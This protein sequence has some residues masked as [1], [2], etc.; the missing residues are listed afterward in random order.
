M[1]LL[2]AAVALAVAATGAWADVYVQTCVR[3]CVG[4]GRGAPC[5]AEATAAARGWGGVGVGALQ[6]NHAERPSPLHTHAC[7]R[8]YNLEPVPSLPADFGPDIDV[9]GVQGIL[10][11][12]GCVRAC[13]RACG[14]AVG[15][16]LANVG[17]LG[18]RAC[19][20]AHT[21]VVGVRGH[22]MRGEEGFGRRTHMTAYCSMLAP[23][24]FTSPRTAVC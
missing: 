5:P 16:V 4:A 23:G 8:N 15:C 19:M 24:H 2:L 7:R 12:R 6:A 9:Q 3:A 10:K 18:L 20:Q 14:R 17:E 22:M 1:L 11:V 13:G 21:R